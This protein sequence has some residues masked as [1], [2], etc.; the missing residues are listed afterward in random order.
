M[1]HYKA[2]GTG[3]VGYF[4]LYVILN[5][6]SRY[7]VGW[8]VAHREAAAPA[9]KLIRESCE[10]QGIAEEWLIILPIAATR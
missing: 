4:Y 2:V 10:K 7:V 8:M 6:F 5:I 3:Q 9:T 1:G